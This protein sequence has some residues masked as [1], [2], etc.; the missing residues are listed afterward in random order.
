MLAGSGDSNIRLDDDDETQVMQPNN[1]IVMQNMQVKKAKPMKI[2]M[3][4]I[5]FTHL[6]HVWRHCFCSVH[7]AHHWLNRVRPG[8]MR[9]HLTE[10]FVPLNDHF[11]DKLCFL[12]LMVLCL[13]RC[14]SRLLSD[15]HLRDVAILARS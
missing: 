3:G 6:Y 12:G 15:S 5:M 13:I 9:L 10:L 2:K 4:Q 7:V 14:T 1:N 8:R 11:I